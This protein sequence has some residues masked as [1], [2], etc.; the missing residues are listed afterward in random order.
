MDIRVSKI[1]PSGYIGV[2]LWPFGIYVSEPR[3]LTTR[4]LLN[5]ESTHWEQQKE[6]IGIFFYIIYGLEWA[7]K[8]LILWEN[9]YEYLAAEI[10]ANKHEHDNTYL[11]KR[12]RYSWLKYIFTI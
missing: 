1:V 10:E 4:W 12:K 3:W 7:I 6:L 2:T 8:S 11:A 9:A 5:H